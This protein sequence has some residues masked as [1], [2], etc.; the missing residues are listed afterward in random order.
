MSKYTEV[1]VVAQ[2]IFPGIESHQAAIM[3]SF[4]LAESGISISC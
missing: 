3:C 4:V 1:T 2:I